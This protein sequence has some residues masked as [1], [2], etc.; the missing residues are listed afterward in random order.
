M[1][2]ERLVVKIVQGL[3]SHDKEFSVC[4]NQL[5]SFRQESDMIIFMF[6]DHFSCFGRLNCREAR[7]ERGTSLEGY[8]ANSR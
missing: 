2:L 6:D 3:A 8:W 7:R 1:K 5:K 4:G